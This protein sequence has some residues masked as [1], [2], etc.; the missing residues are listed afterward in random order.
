MNLNIEN[1]VAVTFAD[2][3]IDLSKHNCRYRSI[4]GGSSVKD[5]VLYTYRKKYE[6]PDRTEGFTKIIK[7][8]FVPQF[9]SITDEMIYNMYL[10]AA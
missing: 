7:I 6:E 5:V 1:I 9:D 4:N 10:P 3:D 2:V 8:P